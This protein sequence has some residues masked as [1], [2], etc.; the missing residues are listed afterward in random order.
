MKKLNINIQ[1][2]GFSTVL[3]IQQFSQKFTKIGLDD[4][5]SFA[6]PLKK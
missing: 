2:R 1:E 3:I 5:I 4:L 6:Y